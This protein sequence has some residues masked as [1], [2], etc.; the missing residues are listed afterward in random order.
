MP[1]T[2]V[3]DAAFSAPPFPDQLL[4]G[5]P[6]G[7][8]FDA[9]Q[10]RLQSVFAPSVYSHVEIPPRAGRQIWD[11]LTRTMPMVGLGW[12]SWTAARNTGAEFRGDL[13]FP[14]YLLTRQSTVRGM[15]AGDTV[16]PG[17]WGMSA[18]AIAAL[19]GWTLPGDIG[20]ARVRNA[21][22]VAEAEWVPEGTAFV[23]LDVTVEGVGF[24]DPTLIAE[25][26][27]FLRLSETF[28]VDNLVRPT[29]TIE[30]GE[31]T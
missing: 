17:V 10:L 23:A 25:L 2:P 24:D 7:A 20:T 5:G 28:T 3:I 30:L 26:A 16:L 22:V 18:L 19:H 4:A 14:L 13:V 9:I 11:K 31:D 12:L 8:A 29:I 6:I 27:D 21:S 1:G 15:Y